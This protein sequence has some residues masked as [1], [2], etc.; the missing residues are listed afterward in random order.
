MRPA[1]LEDVEEIAHAEL[2]LFP[3]ESWTVFQL[4]EEI[5]HPD[6]RYVLA[7]DGPAAQGRLLGYAGIMV[8]GDLADLHTIGTLREGDGIGRALLTWCE[9][10]A[11]DA[12]AESMLLE[13]REDNARARRFYTAAGYRE[14]DRRRGYYRIRGRQID[15]LVMQR[16]LAG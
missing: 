2:E 8:A 9:Q 12:G 14:I 6:R 7:A 1:T 15:A 11:R 10:Q 5:A 4:A 16:A 3:D 13:V